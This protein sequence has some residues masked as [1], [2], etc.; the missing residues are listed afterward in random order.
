MFDGKVHWVAGIMSNTYIINEKEMIVI[1]LDFPSDVDRILGYIKN[2]LGRRVIEISLITFTHFHYDHIGGIECLARLSGAK[3]GAYEYVKEYIFRSKKLPLPSL[4]KFISQNLRWWSFIGFPMP[5]FEDLFVMPRA[6][7]PM[8]RNRL[9][10][11][12]SFWFK[13]GNILP[14]SGEWEVIHTPG[15]TKDSI[16]FYNKKRRSLISGDMVTNFTGGGEFCMIVADEQEIS[17]SIGKLKKI[18]VDSLFPGHG[19]PIYGV[20][21]LDNIAWSTCK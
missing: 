2:H 8:I 19:E 18:K 5:K 17:E 11:E 4:K 6:G 13:D 14:G 9:N 1:D 12:I 3:M 15:H 16:C 10:I 20:N 21:I 7:V